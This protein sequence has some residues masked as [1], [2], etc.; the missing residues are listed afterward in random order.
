MK[1]GAQIGGPRALSTADCLYASGLL[2]E[3]S[4]ALFTPGFSPEYAWYR[5]PN[6]SS[7]HPGVLPSCRPAS[8]E[9]LPAANACH[10][11][12]RARHGTAR[13]GPA[14]VQDLGLLCNSQSL[15]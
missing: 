3:R 6:E 14:G 9:A 12:F 15:W 13:L 2:P 8:H 4:I 7:P 1:Y 10:C 11:T 5:C